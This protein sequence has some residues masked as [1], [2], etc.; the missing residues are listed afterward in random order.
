MANVN[1]TTP[2]TFDPVYQLE[3]TDLIEGGPGG[4]DNKQALALVNRTQY[5]LDRIIAITKKIPIF[6][7][8]ISGIDPG[9][10]TPGANVTHDGDIVSATIFSV[11]TSAGGGS[12]TTVLVTFPTIGALNAVP[13]KL[14]TDVESLGNLQ[15]DNDIGSVV[16]KKIS[17]NASLTSFYV[18]VQDTDPT[19]QSLKIYLD[20]VPTTP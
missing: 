4:N 2:A 6:R 1:P 20:V 8:S 7:G 9:I 14:S 17:Q 15:Q 5:L 12:Q 18:T 3:I 16:V 19:V 11:N 13:H 10:G